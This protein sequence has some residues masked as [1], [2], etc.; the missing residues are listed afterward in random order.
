MPKSS[1]KS[2]KKLPG[3]VKKKAPDVCRKK[4]DIKK[5]ADIKKTTEMV[6]WELSH[7]LAFWGLAVLL[8]L[9]PYF[10]GLFFQPEQERALIFAAVIFWFAW[11]WKWS[12][13]DYSLLSHPLDYFVLAFPVVYLISAF[14]AVNY[15]LAVDDV[16]KTTLYLL[17]YW[18]ASRLV[19]NEK[20]IVT[21]LQ[22]I[23]ISAVGVA[24]AG[25]ATATGIIHINDGFLNGRIYS[26][27]QYPNALASF[28]AAATFIGLY[29]WRKS[30]SGEMLNFDTF[31]KYLYVAGNFIIFTVLLGTKSQGGLLVF[32]IAFILFIIG[33]PKGYRLPLFLHLLKISIPSFIAIWLF[34][35]DVTAGKMDLA[36]LWILAGLAIALVGQALYSFGERKGMFRWIAENRK[37]VIAIVLLLA[38]VCCIGAAIYISGHGD[39]IKSMA[40]EIRLRNATERTY[41]FKD[42][43]KMFKERP[44]LGWGG[45]GW[46]EAYRAYQDYLYNSNQVHG[47]YFQI[48][49]EV[50]ILGFLVILGIWAS[51]LFIAHKLYHE[52]KENITTR[53]LIWT[54]T[55]AAISIGAHAFIDF[56]LSLSALSL[57][58]WTMFG[59][60]AG[61]KL[62]SNAREEKKVKS[63]APLNNTVMI[64]VSI[65]SLILI[66]FAGILATA[67][68]LSKQAVQ[69][70]QKQ[71]IN[72][73]APLLKSA[74]SYNPINPEYHSNMSR[75]YQAQGKSDECL[76]EAK[77][78]IELSKYSAP[79]YADISSI[80]SSLKQN[81]DAIAYAEKAI[82]L[83]PYQ[84]Q[85]YE[86][87]AR[88]YFISGITELSTGNK[89]IARQYFEKL[90]Q[91][92]ATIEEKMNGLNDEQKRLWNMAPY[93]TSTP[94]ILLNLGTAQYFLGDWESSEINLKKA[95]GDS[96]T[97]AEALLWLSVLK[98]KQGNSVEADDLLQ[99]ASAIVPQYKEQYQVLKQLPL[100]K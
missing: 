44:I 1:S 66:I 85:W 83:A 8:F 18:L 78:A 99:Q 95:A 43:M 41:F 24:L 3:E 32:S 97:K 56:D 68:S 84:N 11:L 35:S 52:E 25:L 48:M 10:R 76:V 13:Q 87:L 12:K 29:L 40:Q 75:V 96:N 19:R 45:G 82:S 15:G 59:I 9:P 100:I 98:D 94:P 58:L 50:G 20:D 62:N 26:T 34:L 77:R 60:V 5:T 79:R 65:A 49:V 92:P 90:L 88:V 21:I 91:V 36:W 51:F 16:V 47:Y 39:A 27:F 55:V 30:D 64:G 31:Y 17:V 80:Y 54:V 61:I 93:M 72:K 33:T 4:G 28:L 22:V 81:I 71:D 2:N 38:V 63:Y 37:I 57:V 89:D 74:I 69:Y 70:F 42:A 14:Q 6:Q 23:Y 73:G 7:S 67:N 86:L 46:Q 53:F